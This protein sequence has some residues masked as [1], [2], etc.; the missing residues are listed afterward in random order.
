MLHGKPQNQNKALNGLIWQRIPKEVFVHKD[1]LELG[2]YDTVS[3]FNMDNTPGKSTEL[4]CE[5]EDNC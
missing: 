4:V 1:T 2:V 5:L 3:H